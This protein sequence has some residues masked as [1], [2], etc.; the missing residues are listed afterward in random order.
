MCVSSNSVTGQTYT[1]Y[2]E[3]YCWDCLR[4]CKSGKSG[5]NGTIDEDELETEDSEEE[6][7]IYPNPVSDLLN[8]EIKVKFVE[9]VQMKANTN[10]RVH[11]YD[12]QGNL[13]RQTTTKGGVVQFNVSNLPNGIYYLHIYDGVNSIPEIQQILVEHK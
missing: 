9:S 4:D 2:S 1:N 7:Y 10:Y 3:V 5:K 13:L 12:G 11:L 8:I 6:V